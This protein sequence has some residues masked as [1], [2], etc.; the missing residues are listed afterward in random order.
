MKKKSDEIHKNQTGS[1]N[2]ASLSKEAKESLHQSVEKYRTILETIQESYFEVD[3]TGNFTFFNDSLCHL[4]GYSKEELLGMNS[5]QFTS[6]ETAK[7]VFHVFN[8][9]YNTG[10]PSKAFDWQM[11]S[12]NGVKRYV[13]ASASLL[14]DSSGN[15]TGFKGII[16]DITERK[17]AE[18]SLKQSEEKYRTILENIEDGYYEVD[19]DGNFTFFND[20]MCRIAGCTKEEL[21]GINYGEFLDKENSKK[22]FQVFNKVYKT[23]DPIERFDWM[24]IRKDGTKRYIEASVSLIK[25]SSDKS[26]GFRGIIR[27]ITE[28]KKIEEQYR[29]LADNITEH[30]WLRE[31]NTLKVIYISPSV[32]KMYGYPVDEIRNL[33]LKKLLTEESFQKMIDSF[34]TE[35]PKALATLPPSVH[36][37]S[38]ETQAHHKDGH[39]LWMDHTLSFIRDENGILAF[40]LGETRDVTKRKLAEEKLQQTLES[41]KRAVG[42]TIQVL[43]SALEAR[44]PYTAGHQSRSAD[45]ARAI[46]TEMGL[47]QDKIEGIQMAS[48]IHDIGKL[49]V[50]TEILTKPTKLTDIEFSLIKEHSQSGYEMLK[51]VESPWPLAQIVH[52]H[53]ERMDGS[54]YPKNL[55][56]D[57]ILLE[58][59]IL[60]V[61]DVVEAMASH[62]PYRP[63]LGIKV[64]LE[65]IEKNKGVFY[66]D[67]VADVCLR[68]FRVKGFQLT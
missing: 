28:R 56:G 47:P 62:R 64:A 45:L 19:L 42:T 14:K 7:E 1:Q 54:G 21:V 27:D 3:L 43:V 30:V 24:I 52:Q 2:T 15:P 25:D 65:E 51:D 6:K 34:I 50:P 18:E 13:E 59:R 8:K 26:T 31:I 12:K 38:F 37:Y 68:L 5:R 10:E 41:L 40:L 67:D 46:A 53:H 11:T 17:K 9:I 58:A 29:L 33:P 60:A 55:K 36:K 49:A 22:L 44:D 20:S 35:M 63:A 48:I 61:A 16:R 23:G 57:E 32:E 39:L 4:S 66:D